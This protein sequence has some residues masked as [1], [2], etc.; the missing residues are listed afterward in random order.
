MDT[1]S[2]NIRPWLAEQM[3]AAGKMMDC[4]AENA[5]R[6]AKGLK[7]HFK[8]MAIPPTSE[9]L[10]RGRV[11]RNDPCPCGSG[12]KFKRCCFRGIQ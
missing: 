12:K 11:G 10:E 1:R 8:Q 7:Q 2:G 3:E 9:Q 6:I 5:E 4:S